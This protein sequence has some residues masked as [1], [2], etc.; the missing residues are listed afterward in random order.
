MRRPHWLHLRAAAAPF[1]HG[2]EHEAG[3]LRLF[4]SY[5]CSRYN[6]NTG[7][8]TTAMFHAV[9]GAVRDALKA[10]GRQAL[11]AGRLAFEHPVTGKTIDVSSPLPVDFRRLLAVLR[12]G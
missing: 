12:E 5:H 2:A 10:F 4:D 9:F 3:T 11:H 8:L 6:T 7:R 1:G